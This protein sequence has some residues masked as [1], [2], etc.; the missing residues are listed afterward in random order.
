M[1]MPKLAFNKQQNV[2]ISMMPLGIVIFSEINAHVSEIF[3]KQ[4]K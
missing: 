2:Q 3:T 1:F 4:E